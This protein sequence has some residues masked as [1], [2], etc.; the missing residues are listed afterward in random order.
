MD[1]FPRQKTTW[2]APRRILFWYTTAGVTVILGLCRP[3]CQA[4]K[5]ICRLTAGL[6]VVAVEPVQAGSGV[7]VEH[8]ERAVFLGQ[9]AHKRNQHRVFEHV[10]VV[11]GMEGVAITEH[12][13]M[14]TAGRNI[15]V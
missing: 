5:T 1:I 11:A 3:G 7:G 15:F 4:Q 9:M 8:G 2:N 12:G 14:V 6:G 13:K 10:G